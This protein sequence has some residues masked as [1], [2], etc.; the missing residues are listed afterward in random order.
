[1]GRAEEPCSRSAR[2]ATERESGDA[3]HVEPHD[4]PTE[5]LEVIVGLKPLLVIASAVPHQQWSVLCWKL[6]RLPVLHR[7]TTGH[8]D[9]DAGPR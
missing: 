7:H 8:H 4:R 9:E 1:M 2:P 5:C 6:V 3:E